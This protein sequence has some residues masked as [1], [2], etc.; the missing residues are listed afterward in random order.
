M[1]PI[2]D[3]LSP[4]L[5][6]LTG[7]LAHGQFSPD[8]GPIYA[9]TDFT[10]DFPEPLNA[11]SAGI[12]LLLAV[13]WLIKLRGRY[14]H[15]AF[16]VA[17]VLILAVGGVGGTVYHTFRAHRIWLMM[18]WIPI[19]ILTFIIGVFFWLR[20]L[21]GS[22]RWLLLGILPSAFGLVRGNWWLVRQGVIP[23]AWG[24]NLGYTVMG[25]TSI[26]PAVVLLWKT[27]FTHG[28]WFV[29]GLVLFLMAVACR[30]MDLSVAEARWFSR[31]SHWLWHVFG[32]L[33]TQCVLVFIYR[34]TREG[35]AMPADRDHHSVTAPSSHG[36]PGEESATA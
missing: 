29:A 31:G 1:I 8:G 23:R 14:L 28:A 22:W 17:C 32:A 33:G 20:V 15:H 24:I 34:L 19:A 12:F 10:R 27:R 5:R 25:L 21:R 18:D 16:L 11:I 36:P 4:L 7:I 6:Q 35:E 13:Y 30:A 9:E 26:I 2:V 3:I